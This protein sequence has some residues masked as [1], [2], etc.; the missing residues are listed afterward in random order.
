MA[1]ILHE[2]KGRM[3]RAVELYGLALKQCPS[4]PRFN[5]KLGKNL[6]RMGRHEAA[7]KCLQ[8]AAWLHP[9]MAVAKS[10]M[11]LALEGLG[12]FQGAF[13]EHLKALDMDPSLEVSRQGLLSLLG[14]RKLKLKPSPLLRKA[15]EHV[16]ASDCLDFS[17]VSRIASAQLRRDHRLFQPLPKRGWQPTNSV[18][19]DGLFKNFLKKAVNQDPLMESFLTSCRAWFLKALAGKAIKNN[20]AG[21]LAALAGQCLIN[22]HVFFASAPEERF[23]NILWQKAGAKPPQVPEDYFRL[24]VCAMY[25][26]LYKLPTAGELAEWPLEAWPMAFRELIRRSLLEPLAERHYRSRLKRLGRAGGE[27]SRKTGA[28][29]GESP[30]PHWEKLP[31]AAPGSLVSELADQGADTEKLASVKNF[32]ALVAGCGTGRG[33]L[34]LAF[35]HPRLK[36]TGLDPDGSSLAYATRKSLELSASNVDFVQGDLLQAGLLGNEY[37][38]IECMGALHHMADPLAG[39]RALASVLAAGGVMKLGLW[40]KAGRAKMDALEQGLSRYG[41]GSTRSEIR[42]FRRLLLREPKTHAQAAL[43][44]FEEFYNLDQCRA[45]FSQAAEH[46]FDLNGIENGLR[47]TGLSFVI[48]LGVDTEDFKRQTKADPR[49]FSAW[50]E[51]EKTHPGLFGDRYVFFCQKP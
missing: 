13:G 42:K 12:E 19:A 21:F 15:L 35:R 3:G 1:A 32:K 20:Q 16:L 5:F 48:F 10:H 40:R 37:H 6:V 28:N 24:A 18:T 2:G 9:A 7:L 43:L 4:D 11:G 34:G 22:S 44:D 36:V 51:Y 23:M 30:R 14:G 49:D 39:W 45:L 27:A 17:C 41:A 29:S 46:C 47:E 50:L 38:Y 25:R 26:P 8:K 33:A 31:P